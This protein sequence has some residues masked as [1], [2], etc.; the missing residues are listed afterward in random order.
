MKQEIET[1]NFRIREKEDI[2]NELNGKNAHF[3]SE[4]YQ[5]TKYIQELEAELQF[6][7]QQHLNQPAPVQTSKY[8]SP[9]Q[10]IRRK[11]RSGELP[12]KLWSSQ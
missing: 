11:L 6:L 3:E 7:R 8:T 9:Y 1:L 5:L 10:V 12:S 4:S 2:I